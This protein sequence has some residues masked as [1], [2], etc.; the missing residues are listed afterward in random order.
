M[1]HFNLSAAALTS[2]SFCVLSAC[3]TAEKSA[4]TA[5]EAPVASQATVA[6]ASA[7]TT[8]TE[9]GATKIAE[10]GSEE[11]CKRTQVTGT[12]FKKKIC[13]TAAEWQAMADRA[14]AQTSA[15]QN[16]SRATNDPG[17]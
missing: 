6:A 16:R 4:V 11:I 7:K 12:R 1:R 17:L 15:F 13:A 2:L 5:A 3:A 8:T 14:R 9:T 10:D